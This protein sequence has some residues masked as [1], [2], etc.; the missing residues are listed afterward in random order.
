MTWRHYR[1]PDRPAALCT[2][3]T[4]CPP[5]PSLSPSF[6]CIYSCPL[7]GGGGCFSAR[8]ETQIG[9]LKLP[10][11]FSRYGFLGVPR[12][13]TS[14][15]QLLPVYPS[16]PP[17]LPPSSPPLPSPSRSLNPSLLLSPPQSQTNL[18]TVHAHTHARKHAGN[19]K[20]MRSGGEVQLI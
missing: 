11:I 19:H 9:G 8:L 7:P 4:S 1:A 6:P 2:A 14:S 13:P 17:S 20:L 18:C 15:T 5:P 3:S 10:Q 12:S 16:L